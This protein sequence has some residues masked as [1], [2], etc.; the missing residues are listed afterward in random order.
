MLLKLSN[1][2]KACNLMTMP[3]RL[4]DLLNQPFPHETPVVQ[5]GEIIAVTVVLE[6]CAS[7]V[8]AA[9]RMTF[10]VTFMMLTSA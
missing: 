2:H 1:Q 9:E 4:L 5:R 3:V 10:S 7:S 6:H 8:N